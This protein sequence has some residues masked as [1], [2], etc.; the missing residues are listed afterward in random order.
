[1]KLIGHGFADADKTGTLAEVCRTE[2]KAIDFCEK[3]YLAVS[4]SR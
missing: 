2:I 4:V 3:Y 1:M